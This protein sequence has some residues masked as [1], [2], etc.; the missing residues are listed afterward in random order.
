MPAV[1]IT[2]WFVSE[3]VA[4]TAPAALTDNSR[5]V[6]QQLG[7]CYGLAFLVGVA[8]LYTSNELP[9]VRNYLKALWLADIGHL[10][11]TYNALQ[12]DQ[13][14]SVA[15]WNPMTWGNV[16][17]TVCVITAD[18]KSHSLTML[19]LFL[20]LTRTVYLLG[21]FGAD[22]PAPLTPKKSQ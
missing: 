17:A 18:S 9:V 7:N 16:G 5:L 11:L 1:F 20:F 3:Q 19:K 13:F 12:Y 6:A 15:S 14:V 2:D 4:R 21:L 10:V 8:V 22:S